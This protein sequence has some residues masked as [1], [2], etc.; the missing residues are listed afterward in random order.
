MLFQEALKIVL[1]ENKQLASR[2]EDLRKIL[3]EAKQESVSALSEKN[4]AHKSFHYSTQV[5]FI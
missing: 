4:S 5:H 2:Y 3:M 1:K